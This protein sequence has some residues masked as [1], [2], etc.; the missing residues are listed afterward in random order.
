MKKIIALLSA[1]VI[2]LALFTGCSASK[3][4]K[5]PKDKPLKVS[6]MKYVDAD[7]KCEYCKADGK[8]VC[9]LQFGEREEDI[10]PICED[11]AKTC[12][13]CHENDSYYIYISLLGPVPVC[14]DCYEALQ[15]F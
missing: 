9:L 13:W 2:C 5:V 10:Y 14:E 8:K 6:S 1:I 4:T 15:N 7:E 12:S 11:C 3:T